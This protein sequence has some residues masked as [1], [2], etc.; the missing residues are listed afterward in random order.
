MALT[1]EGETE[2]IAVEEKNGGSLEHNAI[3]FLRFR[4]SLFDFIVTKV[5]LDIIRLLFPQSVQ[6]TSIN[7]ECQEILIYFYLRI[8][9]L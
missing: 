4:Q 1:G 3:V 6:T 7:S 5:S 9:I 2:K 8:V